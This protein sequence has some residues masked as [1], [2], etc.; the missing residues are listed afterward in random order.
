MILDYSTFNKYLSKFISDTNYDS[1]DFLKDINKEVEKKFKNESAVISNLKKEI[2]YLKAS[3]LT[4]NE[5][6]KFELERIL[7]KL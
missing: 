5:T 6:L 2:K 3:S 1:R 7:K 4:K